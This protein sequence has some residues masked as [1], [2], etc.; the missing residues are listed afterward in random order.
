MDGGKQKREKFEC[1]GTDEIRNKLKKEIFCI[2][3]GTTRLDFPFGSSKEKK[4][5][6]IVENKEYIEEHIRK[7]CPKVFP[8]RDKLEKMWDEAVK[9]SDSQF[10]ELSEKWRLNGFYL[11]ELIH[12]YTEKIG[13]E[14][15]RNI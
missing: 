6:I 14:I 10:K 8:K 3:D 9:Y 13:E 1:S 5:K 11:Q 12:C 2:L 15:L 4:K 7:I